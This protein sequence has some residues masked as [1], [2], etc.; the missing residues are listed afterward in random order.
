MKRKIDATFDTETSETSRFMPYY[1]GRQAREMKYKQLK[2]VEKGLTGHFDPMNEDQMTLW[3]NH[4]H[5]LSQGL[6]CL[7]GIYFEDLAR[8]VPQRYEGIIG[9]TKHNVST[10]TGT[11]SKE[12]KNFDIIPFAISKGK[13]MVGDHLPVLV[14]AK[15]SLADR[16]R[17]A[18][19]SRASNVYLVTC[20]KKGASDINEKSLDNF[21]KY[22]IKIVV[23][24]LEEVRTDDQKWCERIRKFRNTNR[25]LSVTQMWD[26]IY[27]T[28]IK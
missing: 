19:S 16:G 2:A 23:P 17:L 20:G 15:T 1:S 13:P 18:Q 21:D 5:S 3:Y 12:G 24:V 25:I 10:N 27:N 11:M 4:F 26:E 9:V 8:Q 22:N 7:N 14:D 28:L 6:R